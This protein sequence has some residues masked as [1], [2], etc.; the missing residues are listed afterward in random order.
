MQRIIL[1]IDALIVAAILLIAAVSASGVEPYPEPNDVPFPYDANLCNYEIGDWLVVDSATNFTYTIKIVS[2]WGTNVDVTVSE[3]NI[4]VHFVE[5]T[6]HGGLPY[7]GQGYWQQ[8][9]NLLW[10]PFDEKIHYIDVNIKDRAGRERNRTLLILVANDP[11]LFYP[12]DK[13]VVVSDP[14]WSKQT[15]QRGKKKGTY[16]AIPPGGVGVYS[17]V[18]KLWN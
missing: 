9:F 1:I 13:P 12:F 14:N 8:V 17:K 18:V 7:T 5:K 10:T 6:H 15:V 3:P 16:P 2:R 4:T 11:P